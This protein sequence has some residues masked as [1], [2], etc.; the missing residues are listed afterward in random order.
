MRCAPFWT[1]CVRPLTLSPTSWDIVIA[2]GFVVG[3]LLFGVSTAMLRR[4]PHEEKKPANGI[5]WPR[6][7]DDRL[8]NVDQAFRRDMI[9]RLSMVRNEWSH[10][11][12]QQA[13]DEEDD[14]EMRQA[15]ENALLP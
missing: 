1:R 13:H 14:P 5:A 9:E 3:L 7:V 2:L 15:I 12:L 10:S 4:Y 11:V 6:L 8:A